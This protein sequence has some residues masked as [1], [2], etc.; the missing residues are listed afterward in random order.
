MLDLASSWRRHGLVCLAL[1]AGCSSGA[2]GPILDG[3]SPDV[4]AAAVTGDVPPNADATL[5]AQSIADSADGRSADSRADHAVGDPP[6]PPPPLDAPPVPDAGR[7]AADAR[8]TPDTPPGVDAATPDAPV[9]P[10]PAQLCAQRRQELAT[11]VCPAGDPECTTGCTYF[12]SA[13]GSDGADGKTPATA[14]Q[15]LAKL[16]KLKLTAGDTLCLRRGDTFRGG[17]QLPY[18]VHAP[19]TNP[20]VIRGYG[21]VTAPRPVVSGAKVIPARWQA[22]SL[23]PQIMQVDL[24]GT[25]TVGAAYQRGGKSYTPREKI[26][27]LFVAGAPQRL[28]TF[29]N[30]GEGDSVAKGLALPGGHYSLIDA[31][32]ARNRMSDLQ[33]PATNTLSGAAIDWA[34]ARFF[35]RQIRWIIDAMEVTGFEAGTR[36]LTLERSPVCSSDDCVGWGYFLVDHLGALDAPGEWYYDDRTQTLYFY[37]PAG[38][39]PNSALIEAS[40]YTADQQP[41]SWASA[42][43]LPEPGFTTGLD[44]QSNS[45]IRV[46]GIVFQ[47]FSKAGV[48]S[49]ATLAPDSSDAPEST[50]AIEILGCTFAYTGPTGVDLERWGDTDAADGGNRISGNAF[51]GQTSQAVILQTTHSEIACNTVDDIGM[52]E[53]YPRFGMFGNGQVFTEHGMAVLVSSGHVSVV[54]NRVQRTASAGISFR[55]PATTVAYNF[56][57]QACY[58]KSDCGGIHTYSWDDGTQFS[59]PS[60]TG[61]VVA[62]NIVIASLGSSEGD[63]RNYDTPMGQGLFLDFGAHDYVVKGNVLALNTSTGILLARN[64]NV[65]VDGNLLYANLQSN[66]WSYVYSQLQIETEYPPVAATVTNNTIAGVGPMQ[67]PMGLR[68][69]TPAQAGTFDRNLLFDPFAY[70]ATSIDGHLPNYLVFVETG[71]KLVGYHLREWT[72]VSGDQ[73]AA[74]SPFYWQADR[75]TQELSANLITNGTFDTGITGW[76]KN[77]WAKSSLTADTHPVLGPSLRYDRNGAEGGGIGAFSNAFPLAAGQT[78]WVHLW[79]AP[80]DGVTV[81]L[82]PAVVMGEESLTTYVPSDRVREVTFLVRPETAQSDC[83]MEFTSYPFLGD[84]FWIDDVVVKQVVAQPYDQGTVIRYDAPLPTDV[85]SFLAYNDT[86]VEQSLALGAGAYVDLAGARHTGTIP[87]PAF[88]AVVLMP[89]AWTR[90]PTK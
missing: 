29:P 70:D 74:G 26:F 1:L 85:R 33:L 89:E 81:P 86:D 56:V 5:D 38:L 67:V 51:V 41:P 6:P 12:F 31:A 37:P 54:Y 3:G 57:W 64:R 84:R 18:G 24:A 19:A 71:G 50:T 32:P 90:T 34:G 27:Q 44:L 40:L 52:L 25:L 72:R 35:Y 78:Y 73:R 59:A 47:H 48:A 88:G 13:Q 83:R 80:A 53:Q 87:V 16:A 14:W 2:K 82:P 15:S 75:V 61:S 65:T 49:I 79:I 77:T 7:D 68:G 22:S 20:I 45:G 58:T 9:V 39:D 30:P 28:A 63:G 55:G 11:A 42:S 21:A 76:S 43:T 46:A 66:T 36:T 69:V 60:I 4:D 17:G 23:A 62:N 8:A 10:P